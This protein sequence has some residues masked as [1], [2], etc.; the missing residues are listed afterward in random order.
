MNRKRPIVTLTTDFG[1]KDSYV[2]EMKG[3][4]LTRNPAVRF[5]DITHDIPPQDIVKASLVLWRSYAHFPAGTIHLVVVDPTV[6][7]KRRLLLAASKK[8]LFLAPDNGILSPIVDEEKE[9]S[10]YTVVPERLRL[11]S[12]SH[13]FEGRDILVPCAAALSKGF[14]PGRIGKPISS[15]T[16]LSQ[17]RLSFRKD[18]LEGTVLSVD[19]FGNVVTNIR[20]KN[21]LHFK[22]KG[23]GKEVWIQSKKWVIKKLSRTYAEEI[24]GPVALFGSSGLLELA[25]QNGNASKILFLRQG[26]PVFLRYG[27]DE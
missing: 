7:T 22:Q 9:I 17:W 21:Y 25:L 6:G 16:T 20:K 2:A 15:V 10:L 8:Y 11:K 12:I 26:S 14:S 3:A 13:T 18:H 5:I 1:T 23:K 19:H 4:I 24:Q 27:N